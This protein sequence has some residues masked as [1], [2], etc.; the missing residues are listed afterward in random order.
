MRS[1]SVSA[2]ITTTFLFFCLLATAYA[3]SAR[4]DDNVASM[5][6]IVLSLQHFPSDADKAKL[7][8]IA[9]GDGSDSVKTVA[10]AIAGINHK[11]SDADKVALMAI[12]ADEGE[13]ADLRQ[14]AGIV[15]GVNHVPGAEAKAALAALSGG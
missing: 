5:A 4:A 7:A 15:A 13:P 11:V 3:P 14:L 1:L 6:G 10:N 2:S 9:G 8:A 12:A